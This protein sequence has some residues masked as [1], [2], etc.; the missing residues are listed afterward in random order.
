MSIITKNRPFRQ[1]ARLVDF[2][3][4]SGTLYDIVVQ[5]HGG[6]LK[7]NIRLSFQTELEGLFDRKP[8]QYTEEDFHLFGRFKDELNAG[9][10]RAAE[11]DDASPTG[12]RVNAWVKKGLPFGF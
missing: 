3:L 12:W 10:I 5:L 2:W 7:M 8:E 4:V 1:R 9:F 6:S 11:P